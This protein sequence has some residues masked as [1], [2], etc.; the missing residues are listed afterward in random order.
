MIIQFKTSALRPTRWYEYLVSF[1]IGGAMT[2]RA[3]FC[4]RTSRVRNPA[5]KDWLTMMPSHACSELGFDP[6]PIEPC[7]HLDIEGIPENLPRA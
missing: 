2:F 3:M 6:F 7:P 1:V 5:A 4:A